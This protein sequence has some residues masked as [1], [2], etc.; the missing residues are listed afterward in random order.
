MEISLV[1]IAF[2]LLCVTVFLILRL[3]RYSQLHTNEV[4]FLRSALKENGDQR[5]FLEK[6][7]NFLFKYAFSYVFLIDQNKNIR[8]FS[9]NALEINSVIGSK[10]N[11]SIL[12]V[13]GSSSLDRLID[14]AF[15]VG[16]PLQGTFEMGTIQKS[17][18]SVT[19][20]EPFSRDSQSFF[21]LII[22]D[23]TRDRQLEDLRKNITTNISHELKTPLS[24]IRGY[25]ET[26]LAQL[27]KSTDEKEVNSFLNKALN[28][29]IR[30]NG[31]ISKLLEISRLE[32]GVVK[33]KKK[34]IDLYILVKSTV[35]LLEP[36][37]QSKSVEVKLIGE[38]EKV[39][40][41]VDEQMIG[42]AFYNVIENAVKFSK[43][44][45]SIII[46]TR[47]EDNNNVVSIIDKGPG[48]SKKDL[49]FIFQRFYM[50][51]ESREPGLGSGLGLA[52]A[53]HLLLLN[54]G[55]IDVFSEVGRGSTFRIV[56][57]G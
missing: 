7:I 31:L 2:T 44:R 11:I 42:Q 49:P 19:I 24:V 29:S 4:A 35:E 47:H 1:I 51:S 52:S 20:S 41:T 13:F 40:A 10:D 21:M 30:L 33:P 50:A 15:E 53:K 18:Y 39:M 26:A 55:S 36:L 14:K 5:D 28:E 17:T 34:R 27:D 6:Q 22:R 16:V 38:E 43:D 56:L 54:G 3:R 37:I 25:I 12:Q 45:A 8:T 32:S 57:P 23:D 46:E 48:I 9:E